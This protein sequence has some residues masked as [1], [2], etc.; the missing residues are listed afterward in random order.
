[1]KVSIR[2]FKVHVLE[3]QLSDLRRRIAAPRWPEKETVTD[4]SQGVQLAT[5]QK[6][7]R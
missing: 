7:V 6:L 3:E 1:M 2:P 4:A 5:M